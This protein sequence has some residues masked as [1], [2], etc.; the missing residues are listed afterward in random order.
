MTIDDPVK[1]HLRLGHLST[2]YLIKLIDS[3]MKTGLDINRK[4]LL[5]C[6]PLCRCTA[7]RLAKANKPGPHP[8]RDPHKE[9]TFGN[10][11]RISS[12]V[13]GPVELVAFDGTRYII[14]FACLKTGY[15][16]SYPMRTKDE[17]NLKLRLVVK[18]IISNELR[19]DAK[20][21]SLY[22]DN[23]S[24]YTGGKLVEDADQFG[25][26]LK[27]SAQYIPQTN[28]RIEVVWRDATRMAMSMHY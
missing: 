14:D 21:V 7:C 1:L 11:E 12:D 13:L 20:G 25:M 5:G 3:G 27:K 17:P 22:T 6:D 23:D 4:H 10:F 18:F 19:P 8:P 16:L 15:V 28:S 26:R 24:I 2:R 9:V